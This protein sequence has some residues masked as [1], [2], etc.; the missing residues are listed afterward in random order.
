MIVPNSV[1]KLTHSSS[2]KTG[3]DSLPGGTCSVASSTDATG[4]GMRQASSQ[5]WA[6]K[7]LQH[8]LRIANEHAGEIRDR[9]NK[10]MTL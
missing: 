6:A 5:H 7:K 2:E 3:F 4:V 10:G 9:K 1:S 8:K